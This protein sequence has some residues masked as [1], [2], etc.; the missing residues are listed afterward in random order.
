MLF[1]SLAADPLDGPH[2]DNGGCPVC[3]GA[4][5]LSGDAVTRNVAYYTVAHASRFVRPGSVRIDTNSSETLPNVAYKTPNGRHVLIVANT[6]HAAQTF[7]ILYHGKAITT[8]LKDGAVATYV[9]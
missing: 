6:A 5:T 3:E 7:Q 1:R 9:W 8:S 2:T 4:I